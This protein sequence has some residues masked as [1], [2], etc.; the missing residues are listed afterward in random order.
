MAIEKIKSLYDGK[1]SKCNR[2]LHKGW[3]IYY[4]RENKI[5]YCTNCG[6]DMGDSSVNQTVNEVTQEDWDSLPE[7]VQ[8]LLD[9]KV[10]IRQA[11]VEERIT[12]LQE[13]IDLISGGLGQL[14]QTLEMSVDNSKTR[15]ITMIEM[16]KNLIDNQP[17]TSKITKE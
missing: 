4:D 7:D 3:D 2:E 16:L 17:K 12:S 5:V 14:L 10:K 13:S 8:A 6:R 11:T 9:G 1:C 15:Q